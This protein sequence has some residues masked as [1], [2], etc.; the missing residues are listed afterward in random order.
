MTYGEDI[1]WRLSSGSCSKLNFDTV[2]YL[3][4]DRFEFNETAHRPFQILC[5]HIGR[6]LVIAMEGMGKALLKLM[7]AARS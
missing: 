4:S 2:A 3:I 5:T 1:L 6:R 7:W